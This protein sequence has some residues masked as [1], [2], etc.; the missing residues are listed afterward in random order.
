MTSSA[1]KWVRR[2]LIPIAVV[3]LVSIGLLGYLFVGRLPA[4]SVEEGA[5]DLV[6][7]PWLQ[8]LGTIR[9]AEGIVQAE[10]ALLNA[11]D[12]N[13]IVH[14]LDTSCGCTS[15]ALF[16]DGSHGPWFTMAGHGLN[17][18]GW[19]VELAP[20]EEARVIVRYDPTAHG[21]YVGNVMRAVYIRSN[22]PDSPVSEVRIQGRQVE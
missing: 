5:P 13:L 18:R 3:I 6:V 4:S 16:R 17:P 20:S 8:D 15:A 19:S 2:R 12:A 21:Y 10:F 9:M 1:N 7:R 14:S 22:D 11:G